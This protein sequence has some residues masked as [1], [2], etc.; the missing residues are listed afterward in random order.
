MQSGRTTHSAGHVLLPCEQLGY[1]GDAYLTVDSQE[2]LYIGKAYGKTVRQR[3][4]VFT[5]R[6]SRRLVKKCHDRKIEAWLAGSIGLDEMPD[7]WAAGADVICIRGADC[8]KGSGPGRF[9]EVK[10]ELVK[11]LVS[12]IPRGKRRPRRFR[13]RR[14]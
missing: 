1:M 9:G 14:S 11:E 12:T 2:V 4:K 3:P 6:P 5:L 8:E 13:A 10:A 7:L